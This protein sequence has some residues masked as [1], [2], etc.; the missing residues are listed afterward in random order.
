[1]P[2][3]VSSSL[4]TLFPESDL[5]ISTC[6]SLGPQGQQ[7]QQHGDI[8]KAR[9]AKGSWRPTSKDLT[10]KVKES[11]KKRKGGRN[12]CQRLL[13]RNKL[14]TCYACIWDTAVNS[15]REGREG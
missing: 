15:G 9:C 13:K 5:M 4:P 3:L 14:E 8:N 1:M 11:N 6:S 12:V 2:W 7:I 10:D